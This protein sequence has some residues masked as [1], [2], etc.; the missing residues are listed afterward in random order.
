[1][2]ATYQLFVIDVKLGQLILSQAN[3]DKDMDNLLAKISQT[4]HFLMGYETLAK[5]D[6]MKE[7][8]AQIAQVVQQCAQFIAN[9]S[10]MK[11]FCMR[12]H[13]HFS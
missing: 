11:K 9:Y 6:V 1:M 13:V 7:T 12:L 8:L 3:L 2:V 5:I 10:E 4:Y